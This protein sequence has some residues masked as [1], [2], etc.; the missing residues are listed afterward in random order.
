MILSSRLETFYSGRVDRARPGDRG[1]QHPLGQRSPGPL[2]GSAMLV[3][4]EEI[5]AMDGTDQPGPRQRAPALI[6]I[7]LVYRAVTPTPFLTTL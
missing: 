1:Q 5:T 2:V 7:S 3:G 6:D 4:R